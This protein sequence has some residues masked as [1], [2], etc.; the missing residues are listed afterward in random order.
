MKTIRSAISWAQKF[1]QNAERAGKKFV[2]NVEL[3]NYVAERTGQRRA[4]LNG[5]LDGSGPGKLIS[6]DWYRG[7]W[8]KV[9]EGGR[10]V[11]R[12]G[13]VTVQREMDFNFGG[14]REANRRIMS[15]LPPNGAPRLLTLASSQG[16]CVKAA[17]AQNPNVLVDNVECDGETLRLWKAEKMR[18]GIRTEDFPVTLQKYV[19][20]AYFQ[21]NQ[22]ALVNADVMGYAARPMREY[23]SV[24]NRLKNAKFIAVTT[25]CLKTFRNGG[26]FQGALRRKYAGNP[27]AHAECIKGWLPNYTL[28]DRF[29]YHK[30]AGT[31]QMEVFI[32][33]LN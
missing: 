3:F 32:F 4:V 10:I 22:Y 25:Q 27:D 29:T 19:T 31:K 24:L 30:T 9:K 1:F 18:S 26:E 23:L 13:K 15:F 16:N 6:A 11:H 5:T 8:Y 33:K 14:K 17:I 28:V 2:T 7:R 20:L 21:G 12:F